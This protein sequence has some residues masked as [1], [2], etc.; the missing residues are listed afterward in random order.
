MIR[1]LQERSRRLYNFNVYNKYKFELPDNTGTAL[2]YKGMIVCVLLLSLAHDSLLF[3][4]I[5]KDIE[6]GIIRIYNSSKMQ[7]FIVYD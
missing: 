7:I 5:G 1:S 6:E 3:K 2:N 4:N